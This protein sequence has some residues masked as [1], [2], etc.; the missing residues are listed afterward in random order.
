MGDEYSQ[1]ASL[2][3]YMTPEVVHQVSSENDY[4]SCRL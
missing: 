1:L 4:V 2:V 3:E